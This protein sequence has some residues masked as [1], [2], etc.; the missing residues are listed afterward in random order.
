MRGREDR[1]AGEAAASVT[2]WDALASCL[3][4]AQRAF[5]DDPPLIGV[6]GCRRLCPREAKTRTNS[7]P[8]ATKPTTASTT[9]AGKLQCTTDYSFQGATLRAPLTYSVIEFPTT[10]QTD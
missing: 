10:G 9:P 5:R 3:A 8:D 7:V 2:R 4:R 6:S 1:R